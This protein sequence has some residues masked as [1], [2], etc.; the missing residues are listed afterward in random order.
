MPDPESEESLPVMLAKT[1]PKIV[2]PVWRDFSSTFA[3]KCHAA[4]ALVFVDEHKSSEDNWR[5]ALDW[6]A[7][8]I[9]TDAPERLIEFLK[10]RK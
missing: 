7:D 2:A 3:A 9:Q 6:G 1:T 10:N 4:G 5:L 8:G